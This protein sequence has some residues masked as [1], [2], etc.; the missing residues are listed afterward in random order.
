MSDYQNFVLGQLD[1]LPALKA[2]AMFGGWGLY[3]AGT[4]FGMVWKDRL[5]FR[6]GDENRES[7]TAAGSKA[8]SPRATATSSNYFE[9]PDEVIEVSVELTEWALKAIQVAA[10][11]A[12]KHQK[13]RRKQRR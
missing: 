4:F 5:F 8:F 2:R 9:V 10:S 3:S 13:P 11:A 7:Y 1:R 6:V 12:P